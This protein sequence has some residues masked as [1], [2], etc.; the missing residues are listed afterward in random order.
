MSYPKHCP[1]CVWYRCYTDDYGGELEGYWGHCALSGEE[2][3]MNRRKSGQFDP[4]PDCLLRLLEETSPGQLPL[5]LGRHKKLD[6][7]IGERLK[8]ATV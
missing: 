3:L 4:R 5:L 1:G 8:G 6:T 7:L 2:W